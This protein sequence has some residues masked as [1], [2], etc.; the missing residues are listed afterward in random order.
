MKNQN[1]KIEKENVSNANVQESKIDSLNLEKVKVSLK[2]VDLSKANREKV[3]TTKEIY[4]GLS[5][6]NQE[7]KKKKR[8]WIRRERTRFINQ[9]LG[10][11]RSESERI[12]SIQKFLI[13]YKE[14][15]RI[16][17]FKI[18]NFCQ[19]KDKAEL[20]DCS[21]LL[22]FVKKSLTN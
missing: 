21:E 22:D 6:L 9:I 13:F 16:T 12:D 11:D 7:E 1:S 8:S 2:N 18:D 19:S 14:N 3:S 15:W 5:E 10:K 17:D 4:L 20:R